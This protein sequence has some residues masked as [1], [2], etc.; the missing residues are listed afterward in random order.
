MWTHLLTQQHLIRYLKF[1]NFVSLCCGALD[2][3][4][5]AEN[6]RTVSPASGTDTGAG[7]IYYCPPMTLGEGHPL[8]VTSRGHDR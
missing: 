6:S 2:V 3:C 4:T 7:E 8:L 1:V 5:Q